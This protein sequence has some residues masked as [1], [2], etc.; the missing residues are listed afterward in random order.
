MEDGFNRALGHACFA[1]DALIRMDV[2]NLLALVKAFHRAYDHAIG[3][4]AG[5]ARFANNVRHE[6]KSPNE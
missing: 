2:Q 6:S 3:V 4:F 5:K 1:V